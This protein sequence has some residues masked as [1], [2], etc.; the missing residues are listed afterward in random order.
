MSIVTIGIVGCGVISAAYLKTAPLFE[1]LRIKGCA[2]VNLDAARARANN[3]GVQAMSVED[4]L[5]DPE[6]DIVVNLT[7]PEAHIEID[8]AAIA[9][10]KHVYSE[11]PLAVTTAAARPLL[12]AAKASGLRVGCAPD[13]FLGGGHQTAR[14]LVDD[15]SIGTPL[16]GTA[17][18]MLRGHERWHPNP[19]FY[20]QPGGGPMFDMG[21]YYLTDLINLLG[22]I[23][24]VTGV[25][26]SG[27]DERVIATGPREGER[28]RVDV[29]T[30]VVGILE[31]RQGAMVNITMSFDVWQH[32]HN[33]IEIYGTEGSMVVPDPNKFGGTIQIA[34]GR[35]E[36]LDVEPAGPYADG[37]FRS[38]GVADMAHAIEEGRPHRASVELA[39][40]VLEV[41]EAFERSAE[42]GEGVDISSICERPAALPVDM[43]AGRLVSG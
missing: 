3:F 18:M 21:P 6:I 15:G 25:S 37:E 13:T 30:H 7:T 24:R 12:E 26:Q 38:I 27:F 39:F 5:A 32:K 43:A 40:H 14:Q 9:A 19:D 28:F 23:R 10:G 16:A 17:F 31:F 29:R 35:E 8:L 36:W 2:D 34:S 1:I 11:K 41:M 33:H 20:Y 42:S 4:L 22:P